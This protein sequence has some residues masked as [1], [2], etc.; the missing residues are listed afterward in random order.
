MFLIVW[1]SFWFVMILSDLY[2]LIRNIRVYNFRMIT[3]NLVSAASKDDIENNRD[4]GWRYEY[5]NMV[6]YDEM[7]WKFW[8]PL[9]VSSFYKDSKFITRGVNK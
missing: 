1:I 8:K 2:M 6:T 9:R 7:L 4:F 5:L 3:L